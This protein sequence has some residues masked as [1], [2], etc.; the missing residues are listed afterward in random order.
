ME[1]ATLKNRLGK[2]DEN[3]MEAGFLHFLQPT[4]KLFVPF[5]PRGLG[6]GVDSE[7]QF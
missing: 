6:F 7:I 5:Q 1:I 4:S 3:E 2:K